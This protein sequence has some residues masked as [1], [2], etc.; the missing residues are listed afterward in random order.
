VTAFATA[1]GTLHADPNMS[2]AALYR[3]PPGVWTALR[4][5]RS[6]PSDQLGGL[7]AVSAR[8]GQLQVDILAADLTD[9]P[10]R[11]DEIKIGADVYRVEDTDRDV[12]ALSWRLSLSGPL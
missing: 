2:I 5:I 3:R 9:E 7:G 4:V 12:D 10:A 11:L 6:Q 1:L 8:A